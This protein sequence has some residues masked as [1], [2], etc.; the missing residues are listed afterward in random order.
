M[1]VMLTFVSLPSATV[2]VADRSPLPAGENAIVGADAY[3]VPPAVTDTL[4]TDPYHSGVRTA[5]AP[6]SAGRST[7]LMSSGFLATTVSD[8]SDV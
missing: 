8:G 7:P 1:P 2:A 3:S 6:L 4:T 5:P